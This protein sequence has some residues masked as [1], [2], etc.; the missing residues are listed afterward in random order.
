MSRYYFHYEI[1]MKTPTPEFRNEGFAPHEADIEEAIKV[2]NDTYNGKREAILLEASGSSCHILLAVN[3][4]E[5]IAKTAKDLIV[6]SRYLYNDKNW[7]VYTREES[8]L[9]YLKRLEPYDR[10]ELQELFEEFGKDAYIYID[11]DEIFEEAEKELKIEKSEDDILDTTLSDSLT[12]EQCI[13]ILRYLF[14]V[15]E[16]GSADRR[17][18]KNDAIS[19]IKAL[20]YQF[21]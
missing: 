20:L 9:F 16:V 17:L 18:A 11:P 4:G 19:K 10:Y 12:E 6:I 15:R 3:E 5:T 1:G 13:A 2:F 21:T 14:S 8:T 7:K